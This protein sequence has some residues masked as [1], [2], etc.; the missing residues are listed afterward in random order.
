M[1]TKREAIFIAA[2]CAA[3]MLLGAGFGS[4]VYGCQDDELS[5][6][7][8]LFRAHECTQPI[9]T[10]GSV[11]LECRRLVKVGGAK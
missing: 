7:H 4:Y 6:D 3:C 5:S 8:A 10:D 9:A 1:D 2:L 11:F